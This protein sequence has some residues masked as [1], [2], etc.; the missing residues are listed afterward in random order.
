MRI[1]Y[2]ATDYENLESIID[3]GK[4]KRGVDGVIYLCNSPKDSAKFIAI[5][6]IKKILVCEVEVDDEL[7]E[8][9]FD[10][11]ESF[12]RCKAYM[13]NSDIEMSRIRHFS[14]YEL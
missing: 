3:Q 4:I 13:Y 5:R 6:G 7:L 11:S 14:K 2:H 1:M 12:F 10:H 9:S 8:E